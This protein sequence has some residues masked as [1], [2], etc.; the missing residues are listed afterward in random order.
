MQPVLTHC[1]KFAVISFRSS[2][3][4][5]SVV[6]VT[7]RSPGG[8]IQLRATERGL[9]VALKLNPSELTKAPTELA[10]EIQLLCQLSA[11]RAQVA[12][13]HDLVARGFSSAVIRGLNLSTDE[14]LANLESELSG[15]DPNTL[16]DTWMNSV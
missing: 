9:P 12:R 5:L 13:R 16:P 2:R 4:R 10:R 3:V 14:E 6:E 7:L 8:G 15:G 1:I 11:K